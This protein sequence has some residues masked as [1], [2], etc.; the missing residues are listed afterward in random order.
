MKIVRVG[1]GDN[2]GP[3]WNPMKAYIEV[4]AEPGDTDEAVKARASTEL[5]N[6]CIEQLSKF[7]G[8]EE[9]TRY[10]EERSKNA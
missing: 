4:E 6:Y 3:K 10:A 9:A 8:A 2:F 1:L 7:K 5:W